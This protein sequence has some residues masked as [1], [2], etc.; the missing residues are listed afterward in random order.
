[1]IKYLA[2][3]KRNTALKILVGFG[4]VIGLSA[5]GLNS[6]FDDAFGASTPV[7]IRTQNLTDKNLKIY[8]IA[9]WTNNWNG[10]GSYVTYDTELKPNEKSDFWFENDGATEFWIVAKNRNGGIEYLKVITKQESEFDFEITETKSIDTDKIQ[11]AEEL[12]FKTDKSERMEKYVL[13][14]NIGLIG[15]LILSLL[16][17]QTGGSK[18]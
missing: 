16:K 9:F 14:S 18:V 6:L 2:G 8:A 10:T 15:L 11:I 3:K 4:I 5:L 13:W 12:T 1:M 17:I 7:N